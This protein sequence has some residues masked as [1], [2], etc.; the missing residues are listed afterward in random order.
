M[1]KVYEYN[2]AG[3]S[4]INVAETLKLASIPLRKNPFKKN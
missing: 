4:A 2:I 3:P 1:I